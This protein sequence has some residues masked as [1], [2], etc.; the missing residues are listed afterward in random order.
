METQAEIIVI[1]GGLSGTTAAL[2][3]AALGRDVVLVR[4]GYGTTAARSGAFNVLG[5]TAH[6]TFDLLAGEHYDPAHE[7]FSLLK[8]R[9]I[10]PY[11]WF[12]DTQ[13]GGAAAAWETFRPRFEA[14]SSFFFDRLTRAG[15]TL[16][17]GIEAMTAHVTTQGTFRWTNFTP[18]SVHRGDVS[19]WERARVA[20]VG[21][22]GVD[23][24]DPAFAGR[25]LAT[26]IGED[27]P[28]AIDTLTTRTLPLPW[29]R[30]R[31]G[32]HPCEAARD[33]DE[34]NRRE[35]FV[36]LVESAL[37]GSVLTHLVISPVL[38][39]EHHLETLDLLEKRTGLRVSEPLVP[40]PHAIH[41]LRLQKAL[42]RALETSPVRVVNARVTG[43]EVSRSWI[44]TLE[45]RGDGGPVRLRAKHYVLATG[46]FFGGG[47]VGR[48]T[49]QEAIFDLPVF[50]QT[51]PVRERPVFS[52][53]RPDFWSRQPA[54]EAG[55]RVSRDLR[56]LREDG[57]VALENLRAVGMILGGYDAALDGT[58]S[59]V[60]LMT[61]FE[62]GQQLGEDA[63]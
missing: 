11:R 35:S 14:A 17:G 60:D 21:I 1:G 13:A 43:A 7:L 50:H 3:A 52:L 12:L 6:E 40:V 10:H 56:P 47:L 61:G 46:R 34:P 59:G 53:L 25:S 2:R 15:Y 32:L 42:D 30:P 20:F 8:S 26:L 19:S 22:D 55:L 24:F 45:A 62:A 44:R 37:A 54:F 36:A 18:L 38:G 23:T 28:S 27:K 4:K 41:G 33:L 16:A 48:G 63:E 51:S 39:I 31:G 5:G 57:K 9:P 29:A 49:V 58:G